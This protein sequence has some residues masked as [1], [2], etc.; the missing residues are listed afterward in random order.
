MKRVVIGVGIVVVAMLGE[1]ACQQKAPSSG[2]LTSSV[3]GQGA[4]GSPGPEANRAKAGRRPFR[5]WR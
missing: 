3:G 1:E 2:A 4:N 5:R